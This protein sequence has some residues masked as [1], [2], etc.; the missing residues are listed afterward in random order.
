MASVRLRPTAVE[1]EA[2]VAG[3]RRAICRNSLRPMNGAASSHIGKWAPRPSISESSGDSCSPWTDSRR[4]L[5][6]CPLRHSFSKSPLLF[7]QH[8]LCLSDQDI[9]SVAGLLALLYEMLCGLPHLLRPA[10]Y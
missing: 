6:G 2:R 10:S 7:E 5:G 3:N 8:G 4:V 1:S 9:G